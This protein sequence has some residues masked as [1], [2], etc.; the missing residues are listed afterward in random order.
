MP[1]FLY[2]GVYRL[3]Q[4]VLVSHRGLLHISAGPTAALSQK[5]V[6]IFHSILPSVL[7]SPSHH[8][9]CHCVAGELLS[10]FPR[11][12]ADPIWR[13]WTYLPKMLW[14]WA[15]PTPAHL[16]MVLEQP[17]RVTR[18]RSLILG[19]ENLSTDLATRALSVLGIENIFN[20]YGPTEAVV[21]STRHRS[22]V[23][24]SPG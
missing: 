10:C 12:R 23:A 2:F 20:E 8:C 9:S 16:A 3:S 6:A 19:G 24:R 7:I 14:T 11:G 15:E 1:I 18:I 5:S 13:C 22:T 17:V 21:G 4:G